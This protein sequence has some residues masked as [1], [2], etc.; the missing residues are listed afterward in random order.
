MTESIKHNASII[1]NILKNHN[2]F[3]DCYTLIEQSLSKRSYR[4]AG[5]PCD[6][7]SVFVVIHDTEIQDV[8]MNMDTCITMQLRMNTVPHC[9]YLYICV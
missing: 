7:P 4:I 5:M 8:H 3:N 1:G 6:L 2:E 9:S